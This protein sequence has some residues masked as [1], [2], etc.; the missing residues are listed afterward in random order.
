MRCHKVNVWLR[1]AADGL[2]RHKPQGPARGPRGPRLRILVLIRDA[3]GDRVL[4]L[5]GAAIAVR[6]K[7]ID[8]TPR[9]RRS[10]EPHVLLAVVADGTVWNVSG[11]GT[12]NV[13]VRRR[14]QRKKQYVTSPT[15][16]LAVTFLGL[17]CG[18]CFDVKPVFA[19]WVLLLHFLFVTLY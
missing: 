1:A 17:N 6:V 15:S 3:D 18:S 19:S 9:S 16:W 2:R 8:T 10:A 13:A 4:I 7:R 11:V 12:L 14:K 5:V